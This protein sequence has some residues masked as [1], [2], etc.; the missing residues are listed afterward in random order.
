MPVRRKLIVAVLA[1]TPLLGTML[2]AQPALAHGAMGTPVSRAVA[3]GPQGAMATRTSAAC[4]AATAAS[5]GGSAFTDWDNLRVPNVNGRDRQLIPDG[6]LCSGGLAAFRGLDLARADWP[7]T[8][9]TAGASYTFRYRV[10]IAHQGGFRLYVTRD[11][12]DPTKPLRWADLEAKPFLTVTDPAMQGGAYVFKGTLPA[13]RSGRQLIYT[14]W[15]TTSTPDTY[16]SCSDVVFAAPGG[17]AAKAPAASPSAAAPAAPAVPASSAATQP[18]AG[19]ADGSP[20][21]VAA[22]SPTS[23]LLPLALI[24]V[25]LLLV[26]GVGTTFLIRRRRA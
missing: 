4:K 22:V 8:T 25:V 15:Q 21:T 16:Y 12:Y 20:V 2:L 14:I 26:I 6:K 18:A 1:L 11:G 23:N 19:A 13:G 9:L 10:M 5:G 17:T 7:A 3:C 24:G